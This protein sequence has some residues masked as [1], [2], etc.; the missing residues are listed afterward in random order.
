VKKRT[1]YEEE[2]VPKRKLGGNGEEVESSL[3]DRK[4]AAPHPSKKEIKKLSAKN[5]SGSSMFVCLR[6][7]GVTNTYMQ[8]THY[9]W[10]ESIMPHMSKREIDASQDY[11][12]SAAFN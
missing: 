2:A 6:E 3:R 7:C 11:V 8:T 10:I 4:S 1:W 5:G 9:Q 12:F